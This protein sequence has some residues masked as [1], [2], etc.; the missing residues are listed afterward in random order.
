M[1][2]QI[3]GLGFSLVIWVASMVGMVIGLEAKGIP[4]IGG[5]PV[6][7]SLL[8]GADQCVCPRQDRR[9]LDVIALKI[10]G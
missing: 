7:M 1:M 5:I 9:P 2:E 6:F 3:L 10:E 4:P 8:V